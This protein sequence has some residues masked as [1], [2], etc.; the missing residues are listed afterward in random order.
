MILKKL[1]VGL[2]NV[3]SFAVLLSNEDTMPSWGNK[4]FYSPKICTS[5]FHLDNHMN[6]NNKENKN[7]KKHPVVA[8]VGC[9]HGDELIGKRVIEDLKKIKL[10]KG[11]LVTIIGN[12]KALK[13]K[14]RF[15]D[16]DLNRSFP[17]K[18]NGNYEQRIAFNLKKKMEEVDFAIDIHS[19]VTKVKDLV[20]ITKFNREVSELLKSLTPKRVALMK[21]HIGKKALTY[22]C[23]AGISLEYGKDNNISVQRKILEDIMIMLARL[24]MVDYEFKEKKYKPE[25][26]R[27]KGT[28]RKKEKFKLNDV[29]E[30]FKLVKERSLIASN[31]KE[32]E[33]AKESF[34][35]ILFGKNSYRDIYGFA[36]K[37]V[38]KF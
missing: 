21:S 23:K 36:A 29:I 22:Y 18:E 3:T 4:N 35:P 19:T 8:V 25:L 9:V 28:V 5:H 15:I 14:R 2:K 20:I 13:M 26:Y 31:G 17:G 10:K 32:K 24:E 6:R 16:Q 30:N 11:K 27:I 7:S 1:S 33:H 34:Y 37:K 38:E 12:E